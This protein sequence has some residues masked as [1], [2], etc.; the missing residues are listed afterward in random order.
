MKSLINYLVF[1]LIS[2]T[3]FAELTD[4][5]F[6][7]SNRYELLKNLNIGATDSINLEVKFIPPSGKKV[8]QAT[9]VRTWE[10]FNHKWIEVE[11]VEVGNLPFEFSDNI[12]LHNILLKSKKSEIGLEIDFIHCDMKGGT[13]ASKKYLTK[14]IRNNKIKDN[15]LNL[16][17][18]A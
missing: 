3:A 2:F 13:C 10:K 4:E 1:F 11:T 9:F 16:T 18:K 14:I 17:L 15:K 6:K 7:N 5:S 12:L 8:N